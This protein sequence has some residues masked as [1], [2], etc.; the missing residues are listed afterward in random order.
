MSDKEEK[1]KKKVNSHSPRNFQLP[2]GVWRYGRYT[3]NQKRKGYLKKKVR[4]SPKSTKRI[5]YKI[6]PVKG[7]KNGGTRLVL[8]RKSVS[9]KDYTLIMCLI[10]IF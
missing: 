4:I 9:I 7:E 5:H 10:S 8:T 2:G 1:K 6:K 3:M